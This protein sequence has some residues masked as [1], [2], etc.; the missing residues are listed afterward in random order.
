MKTMV[1]KFA[2]GE[3]PPFAD[4]HAKLIHLYVVDLIRRREGNREGAPDALR[5]TPW[6]DPQTHV[7][8][9]PRPDR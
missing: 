5:W 6:A 3:R 2:D 9:R 1:R 7:A 8:R 4:E